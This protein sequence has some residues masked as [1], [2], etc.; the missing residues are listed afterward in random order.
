[1]VITVNELPT[2]ETGA[3]VLVQAEALYA[4]WPLTAFEEMDII[5][6]SI[7]SNCD[8]PTRPN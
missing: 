8:K 3:I 1:V 6:P 2:N 4:D 5:E 7:S